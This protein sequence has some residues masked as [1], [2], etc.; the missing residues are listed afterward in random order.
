MAANWTGDEGLLTM[1]TGPDHSLVDVYIGGTLWQSYDGYAP[2]AGERVIHLPADALLEIRNRADRNIQSSGYV[3]RFKQLDAREVTYD[4]RTIA[5]TYDAL[6]RLIEADYD[7]GTTVYTYGFDL[8]GNL[9]N[10]NGISRTYNAANQL[11]NDG[12]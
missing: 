8:A 9:T 7:N 2:T 3:I 12:T 5:Y 11:V 6:S 4:E 10:L 1:G